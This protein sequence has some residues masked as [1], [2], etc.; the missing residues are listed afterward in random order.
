L[1]PTDFS[2]GTD[3]VIAWAKELGRAFGAEVT[4]MHALNTTPVVRAI[5][6]Q[7]A[8][9]ALAAT[10]RDAHAELERLASEVGC[11]RTILVDGAP[12]ETIA[13]VGGR[14]AD[15]IVMGTHGRSGINRALLGS[16]AESVMRRSLVPV[17]TVRI[18]ED[19]A[20]AA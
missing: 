9:N 5:G 4:I 1:L 12:E 8:K 3:S 6:P 18:Q 19:A 14:E 16:V 13:Q 17:L 11:G 7:D 2:P 10:R 20:K 15:L